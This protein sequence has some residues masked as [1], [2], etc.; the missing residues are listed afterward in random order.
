MGQAK[1]RGCYERRRKEAMDRKAKAH[2]AAIVV[3]NE[4][5]PSKAS[6]M[7]AAYLMTIQG[8]IVGFKY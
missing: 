2:Q 6:V 7:L 4:P 3:A 8:T 1:R 5:T